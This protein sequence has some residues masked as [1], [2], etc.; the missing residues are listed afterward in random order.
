MSMILFE[1]KPA[2]AAGGR[3]LKTVIGR[4][5]YSPLRGLLLATLPAIAKRIAVK[6]PQVCRV[7]LP[8]MKVF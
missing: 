4:R 7:W 8:P 1:R 6:K 2:E 5:A 3:E